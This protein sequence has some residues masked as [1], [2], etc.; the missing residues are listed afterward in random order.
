M[1]K[2]AKRNTA[3]PPR[4]DPLRDERA[5][6]PQDLPWPAED[7][8]GDERLAHGRDRESFDDRDNGRRAQPQGP[9]LDPILEPDD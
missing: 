3:T 7:Q 1:S 5:E 8:S 2:P 6:P 9:E 4:G